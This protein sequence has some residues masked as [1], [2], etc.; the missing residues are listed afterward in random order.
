MCCWRR[1]EKIIWADRVKKL[2]ILKIIQEERNNLHAIKRRKANWI[3]HVLGRN[4][5][6]KH[7]IGG[8]VEVASR[9]GRRRKQLFY[10]I[11]EK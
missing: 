7:V 5:L 1:M 3:G 9:Q 8:E 10:D 4:C 2:E 11:K 6:V